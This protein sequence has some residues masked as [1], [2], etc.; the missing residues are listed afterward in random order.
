MRELAGF[1]TPSAPT[2]EIVLLPAIADTPPAPAPLPAAVKLELYPAA[3]REV[4][5]RVQAIA[6]EL[7]RWL[8]RRPEL[9]YQLRPRQ[10]E[11]LMAELYEREGFEVELTPE[12]RDGGVDLFDREC[13]RAGLPA[14]AFS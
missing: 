7:I 12:T 8:A 3:L 2:D 5:V 11:E 14:P 9:L 13:G 4:E 10:L 1:D 6:D